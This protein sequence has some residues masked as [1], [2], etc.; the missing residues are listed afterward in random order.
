M[1]VLKVKT[2]EVGSTPHY[3]DWILKVSVTDQI[4][5]TQISQINRK[6]KLCVDAD[7]SFLQIKMEMLNRFKHQ[8]GHLFLKL[9]FLSCFLNFPSFFFFIIFL[10]YL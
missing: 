4:C 7:R 9:S 5:F 1:I 8:F 3:L 2:K 6:L 10:I